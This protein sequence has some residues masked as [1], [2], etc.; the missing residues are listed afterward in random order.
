MQMPS[1]PLAGYFHVSD[2]GYLEL[3]ISKPQ[4]DSSH[5]HLLGLS[6]HPWVMSSHSSWPGAERSTV[7]LPTPSLKAQPPGS[8]VSSIRGA[9]T[10]GSP[11]GPCFSQSAL[12]LH[13]L[14]TQLPVFFV[15]Q[16]VKQVLWIIRVGSN[17]V[18]LEALGTHWPL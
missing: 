5:Q 16:N 3:S 8:P 18:C 6:P 2:P 13:S 12:E 17:P 7:C 9:S 1:W 15:K 4:P 14:L 10:P 11:C